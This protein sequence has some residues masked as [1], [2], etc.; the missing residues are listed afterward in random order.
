MKSENKEK[1]AAILMKIYRAFD[2]PK[3]SAK[4][5]II[6]GLAALLLSVL[7]TL[8]KNTIIMLWK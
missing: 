3:I 2:S 7:L 8:L 4:E 5:K 1:L 6:I